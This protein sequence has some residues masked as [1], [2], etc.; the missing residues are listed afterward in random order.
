MKCFCCWVSL[1]EV[2]QKNDFQLTYA[3]WQKELIK[4]KQKMKIELDYVNSGIYSD[5][6]L[7]S[8]GNFTVFLV[9]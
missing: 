4:D 3:E 2:D 5:T 6:C 7:T 9:L 1:N 8:K